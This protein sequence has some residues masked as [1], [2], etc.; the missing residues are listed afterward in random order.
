M[1]WL[2]E[3]SAVREESLRDLGELKTKFFQ[4]DK[5]NPDD[6]AVDWLTARRRLRSL[7]S[8][9]ERVALQMGEEII[10]AERV[11]A[12]QVRLVSPI[13]SG[14]SSSLS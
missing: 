8:D 1:G 12:I 7:Q 11:K 5:L 6:E 4:I 13:S 10:W 14:S 9:L 2:A 3:N